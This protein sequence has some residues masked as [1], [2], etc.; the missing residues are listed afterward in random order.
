MGFTVNTTTITVTKASGAECGTITKT[1]S[2]V[3]F[4]QKIGV[5]LIGAEMIE[6]GTYMATV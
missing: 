3:T 4:T 1:S 6:I 5:T 2:G